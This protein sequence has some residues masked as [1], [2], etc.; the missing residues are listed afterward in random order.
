M[1][2]LLAIG[3]H[4]ASATVA[5]ATRTDRPESSIHLGQRNA[6]VE[7]DLRARCYDKHALAPA[8]FLA[9]PVGQGSPRSVGIW[10]GSSHEDYN[11]LV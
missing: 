6:K 4:R 9:G 10:I 2:R 11:K 1:L 7:R 5:T 3:W 8:T